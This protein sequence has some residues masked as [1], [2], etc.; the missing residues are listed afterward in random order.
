MHLRSFGSETVPVLDSYRCKTSTFT[1]N[2]VGDPEPV[3]ATI[4]C[5]QISVVE[6]QS[7]TDWPTL[8]YRVKGTEVG[9]VMV[10]K[11]AG[12]VFTFLCAANEPY[13]QIGQI[14]GYIETVSG[15]TT[16]QKVEQ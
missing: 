2:A 5:K 16:F 12:T 15:S 14:V 8:D 7:V 10:Q 13:F 9:S 6:D 4:P 3:I 11:P 1:V